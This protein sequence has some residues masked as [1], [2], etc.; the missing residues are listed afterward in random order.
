MDVVIVREP[1]PV[2][3]RVTD[4]APDADPTGTEIQRGNAPYDVGSA[5]TDR[6]QLNL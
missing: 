5:D 6:R 1:L 3:L 2:L 4:C